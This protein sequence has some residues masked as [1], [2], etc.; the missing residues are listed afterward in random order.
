[1][2]F[3]IMKSSIISCEDGDCLCTGVWKITYAFSAYRGTKY[4]LPQTSRSVALFSSS[5]KLSFV[6]D[7][8]GGAEYELLT[9]S[10]IWLQKMEFIGLRLFK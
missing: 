1:M 9:F 7:L 4:Q 2:R 5:C 3:P 10:L 8:K 6:Y